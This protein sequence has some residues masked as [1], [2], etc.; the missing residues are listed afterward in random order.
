MGQE[1]L[2]RREVLSGLVATGA[3]AARS[4]PRYNVLFL[5]SDEHSPHAAGFLGSRIVKTPALDSLAR[6]GTAFSAAYCQNPI[7]V[8]SR[9]SF[10]TGRMPSNVGV[11]GNEGG[12][13]SDVTTLADVFNQAGYQT[14]WFGKTHWGGDPRFKA[15]P[16]NADRE[17]LRRRGGKDLKIGRLPEEATVAPWP[18]AAE[19]DTVTKEEAVKFLQENRNRPFFAGVSF[20]KPHFPF[21]VQEN[22]YRIYKDIADVPR[23]TQKMIDELPAVSKQEREKYGFAKLTEQQIRKARAVYFGMVTYIDDLV[24]EILKEVDRLGLRENTIILYIADHGELAG[25]HGLW[26]KNSFYEASVRVPFVWSFPK[27]IPQGKMIGAPVMNMDIFPTLCDL[28]GI[29]KPAGLEGQSLLPLMSGKE[30]GSRRYALSENFRGRSASRMI[31]TDRWKYCYFHEDR[32]Q[33]FDM[34]NDREEVNN[35]AGAPEHRELVASLRS[36]ALAGW[37]RR[38]QAERSRKKK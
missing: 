7:C 36:R 18:A 31:R 33:L 8:P 29:P 25:E 32:E 24:G 9:A 3:S 34:R 13:R 21:I 28:C 19:V 14:G 38:D 12:L 5:M 6:S 10:V 17:A 26:Y 16:G 22:Y 23:V 30:D 27:A 1:L 37:V 15:G 11:F 4:H 35:L 2:S 20:I